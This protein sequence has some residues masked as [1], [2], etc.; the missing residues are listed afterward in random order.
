MMTTLIYAASVI[1]ALIIIFS[2]LYVKAPPSYAYIISGL[3]KTPRYLIG[4]GG[5]RIPGLE[6]VDKLA[7]SQITIDINT[8]DYI[9]TKDFIEVN[10]D[11]V[12]IIQISKEN[13]Q[14]AAKNYIGADPTIIGSSIAQTL[15]GCLREAIGTVDF[16]ELN[17]NRD[18][19]S[20][21]VIKNA[22][23]DISQL[24]LEI[25]SCNIERIADK[26]NLVESLGA[27]NTWKI[28]KDAALTK[29]QNEQLIRETNAKANADARAKEIESDKYIASQENDLCIKKAEL[30]KQSSIAEAQADAAY[31]IEEFEQQKA[32]NEKTVDAQ[33]VQTKREQTLSMERVKVRENELIATI[34]KEADANKYKTETDAKAKYEKEKQEANARLYIEQQNAESL[35]VQADAAKYRQIAEAEGIKAIAE[36]NAERI[37]LEGIAEAEAI[38]SKGIAEA[39]A[40]N[41]KAEAFEKYG[42][43]AIAD[44]IIKILPEMAANV[45]KPISA[46]KDVRIY[47]SD[48]KGID[49]VSGNVPVII[50]QTLDTLKSAGLPVE[51]ML[52]AN[53]KSAKTDKNINVTGLNISDLT[54]PLNS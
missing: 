42:N 18:A 33:I 31:K 37:K 49:A 25:V 52:Y 38:Q 8:K 54:K 17:L 11:A 21:T 30:K 16:K 19:F 9:P 36:A 45:A 4:K 1:I 50:R 22:M 2:I 14:L 43:A 5:F 48:G 40:L 12:A 53:T 47:G 13:I 44:M 24:G 23:T 35:K 20:Q 26:S 51:D 39:E 7:L 27:D 6:R 41:K 10:I 3:S 28:K 15:S 34:N 32:I 29:A 46:I